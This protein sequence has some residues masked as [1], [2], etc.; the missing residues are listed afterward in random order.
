MQER[1]FDKRPSKAGRALNLRKSEQGNRESKC[2]SNRFIFRFLQ[3]SHPVTL[4][5]QYCLHSTHESLN[6]SLDVS[7]RLHLAGHLLMDLSYPCSGLVCLLPISI[8]RAIIR[9][10]EHSVDL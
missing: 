3:M 1:L 2:G 8:N 7:D 10:V 4:R 6:Q 5:R 9:R